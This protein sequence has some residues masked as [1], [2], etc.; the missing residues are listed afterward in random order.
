MIFVETNAESLCYRTI[1]STI[2]WHSSIHSL[3][4]RFIDLKQM[5]IE[6]T[7]MEL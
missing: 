2:D 1:V 5:H 6:I 7:A 4:E 3:K